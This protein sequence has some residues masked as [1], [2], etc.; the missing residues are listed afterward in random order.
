MISHGCNC[1]LDDDKW[2]SKIFGSAT[3]DRSTCP[4]MRTLLMKAV[5]HF[6]S[7]SSLLVTVRSKDPRNVDR[8]VLKETFLYA[9]R[10]QRAIRFTRGQL[11]QV[12]RS[13]VDGRSV[14][15]E[16]DSTNMKSPLQTINWLGDKLAANAALYVWASHVQI[17]LILDR[18]HR[19]LQTSGVE[20]WTA[21]AAERNRLEGVHHSRRIFAS[22]EY[23]KSL[24]PLSSMFISHPIVVAWAHVP[25]Q[26]KSW[27]LDEL[28]TMTGPMTSCYTEEALDWSQD[29]F[30]T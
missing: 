12:I 5:S 11:N 24:A 17:S 19:H 8:A 21:E 6:S 9:L 20:V 29:R 2:S 16:R 22:I 25:L 7:L 30:T 3:F 4:P 14:I 23:V 26:W 18:M 27:V 15:T 10:F 28:Q 13:E 1:L